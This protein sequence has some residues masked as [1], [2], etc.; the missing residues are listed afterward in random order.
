MTNERVNFYKYFPVSNADTKWG[1]FIENVGMSEVLKDEQYPLSGHPDTHYFTWER[2]RYLNSYQLILIAEGQGVFESE[3]TGALNIL[4]GSMLLLYP[5]EWHR[6]R[7]L[8]RT[9]W[10]EYWI[11]FDGETARRL[12][13][14]SVFSLNQPLFLMRDF[15]EIQNLFDTAI[16]YSIEEKIGF[17][18]IVVGILFQLFGH[19][20]YNIKN[21]TRQSKSFMIQINRAKEIMQKNITEAMDT[22]RIA[23]QLNIGYALFRKKFKEFTGLSPKQYLMQL[24]LNRAKTLL[25]GTDLPVKSIAFETGYESIYHFSKVFKEKTGLSPTQFREQVMESGNGGNNDR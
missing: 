17:Q 20:H 19:V 21:K 1:I 9:G 12:V 16:G 7:P 18:Q 22:P 2:G 4:P 23:E 25:L 24:K 8:K 10:K 13:E 6:Y 11:G 15:Q 3:T 5:N 14:G